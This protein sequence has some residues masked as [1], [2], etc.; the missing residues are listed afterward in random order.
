MGR[1]ELFCYVGCCFLSVS[2]WSWGAVG[3]QDVSS[4]D[5]SAGSYLKASP[6]LCLEMLSASHGIGAD[7]EECSSSWSLCMHEAGVER[8]EGD[9][10][11]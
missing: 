8:Q 6:D 2:C 4:V 9:I 5:P 10:C 7:S 11:K 1:W 3:N